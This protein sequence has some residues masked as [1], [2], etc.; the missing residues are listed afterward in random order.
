MKSDKEIE[1]AE[2]Q[3][4]NKREPVAYDTREYPIKVIIESLENG[5]FM[6]PPYQR[7][8]VWNGKKKSKFIESIL[9]DLPIPYLYFADIP[10][11]PNEGKLEI[12]DGSQRVRTI[13][14]FCDNKF[15]LID[16]EVLDKL[17]GFKFSDLSE[18][19]KRR[20]LRKTIR[21]IELTEK[22]S[23]NV[24]RDLFE[25]IN[26]KPYALSA[27]EIRKGLYKGE[28]YDFLKECSQIKEF[29]KLCPLSEA[30]SK[31]GEAEELILRYF[32]YS[33]NYLQF[34]HSVEDFL[35][36]YIKDKHTNGFNRSLMENQFI[37][38]ITFVDKYFPYGFKKTKNAKST[39]RVRFESIAIGVTLALKENSNLIP[40]N[41]EDWM[42]SEQF[43]IHTASGS[44]NNRKKLIG[45]IE[46][47]K[48]MLLN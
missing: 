44:S 41:V 7:E 6:I 37:N 18:S 23:V 33:D 28:F 42:N 13:S 8:F 21:S 34:N 1:E 22:A 31:R 47:V 46:Y 11:K 29:N 43:K 39:P 35:D 12:V 45:R 4:I 17:N 48:K 27:M 32:S 36:D 38:M 20:F 5:E 14:S 19:R 3:I 25:R 40:N 16:L 2:E 9:L 26:T 24:R 10:D 30:S 15:C